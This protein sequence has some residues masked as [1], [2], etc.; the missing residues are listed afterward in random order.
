[1][2]DVFS[3]PMRAANY[4][5]DA[6]ATAAHELGLFDA[7]PA[8]RTAL[9]ERLGLPQRRLRALI[10]ALLLYGAVVEENGQLFA[11]AVP[12]R[13]PL[14]RAGWGLLAEVIRA[15]RPLSSAAV[16]G[17]A[18]EELH[19]FHD[20]LRLAGVDAAREV[21]GWLGRRGPMLDLG[22]GAGVY[23][24]AFLER[25]PGERAIVVDRPDVL[26]LASPTLLGADLVPLDLLGQEPW[27][28]GARV[29]LLANVLH[30]F[31]P[32]DAARLVARAAQAVE[33]GGMVAVKDFDAAS[34]AGVLFSLNMALF[35]E[36]GEVHE[37]QA[38]RSFFADARI[39]DVRVERLRCAP[40]SILLCGTTR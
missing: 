15:D 22:A 16:D 7:L 6:A 36:G 30:L 40:E 34:A 26:K 25:N 5:S 2:T 27:P 33:R 39:R 23:A 9:A 17:A 10:R 12:P 14:P 4:L 28:R 24:A 8:P 31:A 19:R 32:S 11:G 35:T 20:H 13:R 1:V 29:A 37:L 21:A 18:G 3:E 38:L